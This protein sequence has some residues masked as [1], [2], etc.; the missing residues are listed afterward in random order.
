MHRVPL[1]DIYNC[2]IRESPGLPRARL[3]VL[4]DL[5]VRASTP[6]RGDP[7]SGS[8]LCRM[9]AWRGRSGFRAVRAQT[10]PIAC[11]IV[12]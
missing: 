3:L 1:R 7:A 9:A 5:D 8:G 10:T 2:R 12:D 11:P 6:S 4:P